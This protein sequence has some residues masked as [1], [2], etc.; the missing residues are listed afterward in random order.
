VNVSSSP[1]KEICSPPEEIDTAWASVCFPLSD[2]VHASGSVIDRLNFCDAVERRSTSRRSKYL[3][4]DDFGLHSSFASARVCAR[5]DRLS[6]RH[7]CPWGVDI[8]RQVLRV[9]FPLLSSVKPV[10]TLTF[11]FARICC[12]QPVPKLVF[13]YGHQRSARHLGFRKVQKVTLRRLALEKKAA[14]GEHGLRPTG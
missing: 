4:C 11:F 3:R 13:S 7:Q 8:S 2:A 1:T 12:A 5:S 14:G 9:S 6:R 10:I